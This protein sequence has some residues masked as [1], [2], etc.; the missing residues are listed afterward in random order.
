MIPVGLSATTLS[1]DEEVVLF[2]FFFYWMMR[3][4]IFFFLIFITFS[5]WARAKNCQNESLLL[6]L[7]KWPHLLLTILTFLSSP[8][9]TPLTDRVGRGRARRRVREG[10]RSLA[11]QYHRVEWCHLHGRGFA[12]EGK[13]VVS[14]CRLLVKS[15]VEEVIDKVVILWGRDD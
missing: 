4:I 8:L 9:Q 5:S 15:S 14:N 11:S 7:A 3:K 12:W 13:G 1:L 6:F 2:L 10:L